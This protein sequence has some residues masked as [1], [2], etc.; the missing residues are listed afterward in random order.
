MTVHPGVPGAWPSVVHL[1]ADAARRSPAAPALICGEDTLDYA[2]YVAC[3]AGLALELQSLGIGAGDRVALL[4]GNGADIAIATFG[5]QASGA[6]L[7]PLNPAYTASELGP[8]LDDADCK[9]L[10][11]DESAEASVASL[12]P[13][14]APGLAWRVG[15]GARRLTEWR[16]QTALADRLPL[17]QPEALSTLQYTGGTTGRSKGVNLTHRAVAINIAQREA[18]LP[19]RQGSERVLAITPLFHVYAVS[20]GLYLAANCGG[21]LVVAERYRPEW[22][23]QAIARHRITLLAASPTIFIGLMA[24]EAFARSDLSSLRLCYSGSSALAAETLRRWQDATGCAICEGYGQSEAGPVLSYNPAQGMR[25][26]G[27]VGLAVPGTT[28]EIVDVE[29]GTRTLGVGEVGEIRARGP[30]IMSGYRNLPQETALALRDG[31]LHTGDLGELDADGYLTIRDRKKE[32]AIVG[33]YNVYP[34]EVEEALFTHPAVQEAGVVGVPD[35]Y[36]GEVLVGWV[37]VSDP[38]VTAD[39]LLAHLA[40]RLVRYKIPKTLLVVP[41]LPKTAVGKLDKNRLRQMAD[42]APVP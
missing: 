26:V 29:T 35:A 37:V 36:R 16:D 31:W 19:T 24:S 18:L 14:F 15:P 7:V 27:S 12:L 8:I 11:F 22:V 34:R 33:G 38:Q 25:K 13:R 6:Q 41:A 5:V 10:L 23:L 2:A 9:A 1:L 17:P 30:Q 20:M 39:D 42:G 32:M 21:T 3:V 40:Q 28:I 4:M